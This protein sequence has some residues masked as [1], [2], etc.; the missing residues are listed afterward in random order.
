MVGIFCSSIKPHLWMGVYESLS[1]S[2]TLFEVC[3][4]GPIAPQFD[5]PKNM[6]YISSNVKPAQCFYIGATRV[7][8]EFLFN[9][10]D[11]LCLYD[12]WSRDNKVPFLDLML[13]FYLKFKSQDII[14]SAQYKYKKKGRNPEYSTHE[15]E[16]DKNILLPVGGLMH[17]SLWNSIG[18]D[19]NFVALYW[20]ED[21]AM[22]LYSREGMVI[23]NKNLI[24]SSHEGG[25]LCQCEN[26]HDR[27]LWKK[28]WL[29]DNG[30]SL[31][32]RKCKIDPITET[33]NILTVSQGNRGQWE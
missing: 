28:M 4:V 11:D 6:K 30:T 21:I 23:I 20:A 2:K 33:P 15:F 9:M 32:T 1:N 22:E 8:G 26:N 10:P 31:K 19:K 29:K 17:R 24:T 16:Y 18:I 12:Q 3:F 27:N 7:F 14:V 25:K 13:D 5:L